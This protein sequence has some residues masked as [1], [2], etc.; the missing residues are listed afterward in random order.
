MWIKHRGGET[1]CQSC[2]II[3]VRF[4]A[5]F[6]ESGDQ[7]GVVLLQL[8]IP[9]RGHQTPGRPIGPKRRAQGI[10][11]TI[12]PL[13][14]LQER[15]HHIREGIRE[16]ACLRKHQA[17]SLHAR[18]WADGPPIRQRSATGAKVFAT[19]AGVELLGIGRQIAQDGEFL[20]RL[21]GLGITWSWL[22]IGR[23]QL[24][25]M[26]EELPAYKLSY[27]LYGLES[28]L[29]EEDETDSTEEED[30]GAQLS[31]KAADMNADSN[32]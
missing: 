20:S 1:S 5:G 14:V 16:A 7:Q 28:P 26:D 24:H 25:M 12:E 13:I 10:L 30:L 29:L 9:H 17:I 23:D 3:G 32:E 15:V 19:T 6:A 21:F 18:I 4:K 11:D 22:P 8:E 31:S 2:S 27:E